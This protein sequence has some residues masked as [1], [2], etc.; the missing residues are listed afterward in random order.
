MYSIIFIGWAV[1]VS[2]GLKKFPKPQDIYQKNINVHRN[3]VTALGTP[4]FWGRI[5]QVAMFHLNGILINMH[6]WVIKLHTFKE[7]V[8]EKNI[9]S[10][11]ASAISCLMVTLKHYLSLSTA[12][13]AVMPPRTIVTN[14][15]FFNGVIFIFSLSFTFFFLTVKCFKIPLY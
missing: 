15:D 13:R 2:K 8:F 14:E 10:W 11:L 7:F 1:H 6:S 4:C 9:F 5:S 12:C 3:I